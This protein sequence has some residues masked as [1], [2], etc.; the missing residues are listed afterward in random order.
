MES[1]QSEQVEIKPTWRLA[2]GLFWRMF[3]INLAVVG[4]IYLIIFTIGIA[5]LPW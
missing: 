2:W 1:Q 3:L 4:V 5:L